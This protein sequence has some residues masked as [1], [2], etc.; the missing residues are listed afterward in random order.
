MRV[1]LID[2]ERLALN[3]L[4]HQL[5]KI[6][7]IEMKGKYVDPISAREHLLRED[8][9]VV[10]L[11]INLLGANGIEVA[12]QFLEIKPML[13]IVF[14]TA[15][16]EY[17]IKAFEL[18][19][20]D[21]ILKPVGAERLR[22]TVQRM[23]DRLNQAPQSNLV[24]IQQVR[25]RLFDQLSIGFEIE[26]P[27]PI[28]WRTA[29]A[30]ELF[31]YLLQHRG[32]IVRKSTIIDLMWPEYELSRAYS[33]MYTAIYHIRK[34]IEPFSNAIQIV[35]ETDGYRLSTENVWLDVE[36]WEQK[37]KSAPAMTEETIGSLEQLM[38]LYVG[39]YLKQ[40]DY[41][42]AESERHR[43][44]MLWLRTS[45]QMAAWYVTR[46]EQDKAIGK[47]DE[48]CNRYPLAEEAHFALM[49]LFAEMNNRISVQ[50]QYDL[51]QNIL[52]EEIAEQP[53]TYITEW[54]DR[55]KE[56]Q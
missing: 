31:L 9:D 11:D 36:E 13:N 46:G 42:W 18:N 56:Q 44:K 28:R 23:M 2:D 17:A 52:L 1:I 25:I 51:L 39:D 4:E 26:E 49:K 35:N 21:Y 29:R 53:S 55:W 30:Q 8:V 33:Q 34:T 3:Y 32:Q 22:K 27:S 54:Y 50:R 12:E 16:D 14:I 45:L 5:M 38:D 43:L 20:L 7:G 19:A 10:F 40:Y 48:I 37:I 24:Q 15:Y 41:W 47:Y 6:G